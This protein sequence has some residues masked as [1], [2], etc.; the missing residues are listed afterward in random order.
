V[1]TT[2]RPS[3]VVT[4]NDKVL[5]TKLAPDCQ[6]WPQLRVIWIHAPVPPRM[7]TA[8]TSPAPATLVTSTK[9]NQGFP[10]MVNRIPPLLMHGTLQRSIHVQRPSN[11]CTTI[12]YQLPQNSWMFVR[13]N[14]S[15]FIR[16]LWSQVHTNHVLLSQ[17]ATQWKATDIGVCLHTVCSDHS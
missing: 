13:L 8:V 2:C 14:G 5:P 16:L 17:Q 4:M 1:E 3:L 7:E 6:F 12:V 11:L 15:L 10:L 9:S